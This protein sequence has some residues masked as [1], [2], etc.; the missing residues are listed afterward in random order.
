MSAGMIIG[1]FAG[2]RLDLWG[3]TL[4]SAAM[5]D[6]D[7]TENSAGESL[8]DNKQRSQK[9]I[10]AEKE[11]AQRTKIR[12]EREAKALRD[13]LKKRKGQLRERK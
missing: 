8:T 2:L 4:Q 13:N 11:M 10:N 12:L 3:K 5:T 9:S 1:R 6:Q 7:K